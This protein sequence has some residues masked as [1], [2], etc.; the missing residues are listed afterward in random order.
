MLNLRP[1]MEKTHKKGG[2][3]V[4]QHF[5]M[6]ALLRSQKYFL[7]FEKTGFFLFFEALVPPETVIFFDKKIQLP[8]TN[9]KILLSHL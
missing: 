8:K 5:F 1:E 2:G 9:L 4:L 6:C 7:V 3:K